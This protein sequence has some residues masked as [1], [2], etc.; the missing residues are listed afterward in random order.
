MNTGLK[1]R[2]MEWLTSGPPLEYKV[3]M[4]E[5]HREFFRQM[6]QAKEDL[7]IHKSRFGA[8]YL[9]WFCHENA[10]YSLRLVHKSRAWIILTT[11][12]FNDTYFASRKKDEQRRIISWEKMNKHIA[13]LSGA[14]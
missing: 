9:L 10:L 6:A 14:A 12:F 1:V 2:V 7:H 8:A 4:L 3:Q 11:Y 13:S 5:E